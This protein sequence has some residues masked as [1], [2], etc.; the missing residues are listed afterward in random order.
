MLNSAL[1]HALTQPANHRSPPIQSASQSLLPRLPILSRH[2]SCSQP[3]RPTTTDTPS[4]SQPITAPHSRTRP[5]RSQPM[6][7]T[8]STEPAHRPA[9]HIDSQSQIPT[10]KASQPPLPKLPS[11]AQRHTLHMPANRGSPCCLAPPPPNTIKPAGP[12][13]SPE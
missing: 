5:P 8:H 4:L 9:L 12:V 3:I 1:G 13:Y 6:A 10:H 11:P 2:P 7:N